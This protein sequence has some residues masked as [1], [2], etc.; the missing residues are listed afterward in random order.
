MLQTRPRQRRVQRSI[1]SRN[2]S[3]NAAWFDK[4]AKLSS[5]NST[6]AHE[7]SCSI[8]TKSWSRLLDQISQSTWAMRKVRKLK[9]STENK[10]RNVCGLQSETYARWGR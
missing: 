1:K 9:L 8:H 2:T 4:N 7:L 3:T 10:I 5:N 6:N